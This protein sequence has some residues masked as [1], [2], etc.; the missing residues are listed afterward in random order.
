MLDQE[1]LLTFGPWAVVFAMIGFGA[2]CFLAGRASKK[3]VVIEPVEDLFAPRP[4]MPRPVSALMES[5]ALERSKNEGAVIIIES[6]MGR[7][8]Q[9][10]DLYARAEH[11]RD[12]HWRS[13]RRLRQRHRKLLGQA[14]S[15][16][17][18]GPP[19]AVMAA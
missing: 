11:L 10:E 7:I 16:S 6:L 19:K 8:E 9:L 13:L 2:A 3:P 14:D 18:F 17:I 5:L 4:I 12:R 1:T 15:I